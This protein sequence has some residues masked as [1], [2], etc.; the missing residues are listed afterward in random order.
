MCAGTCT[1]RYR[2]GFRSRRSAFES[3]Y[4]LTPS[5]RPLPHPIS[6]AHYCGLR[7]LPPPRGAV[8]KQR[9]LAKRSEHFAFFLRFFLCHKH[10]L[11]PCHYVCG[12]ISN[13]LLFQTAPHIHA[14]CHFCRKQVREAGLY[15]Q[16]LV[17]K[18]IPD[19]A[20]EMRISTSTV[21]RLKSCTGFARA[22]AFNSVLP[23]RGVVDECYEYRPG[24]PAWKLTL[25]TLTT[26]IS[27]YK[28][29]RGIVALAIF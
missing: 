17:E 10:R 1:E 12:D 14:F 27:T 7:S 11:G 5:G 20:P 28:Q 24:W 21:W 6:V 15:L 16:N 3:R 4:G 26:L 9:K 29:S 18:D 22:L 13:R 8:W 25:A 23:H 2:A 19:Q